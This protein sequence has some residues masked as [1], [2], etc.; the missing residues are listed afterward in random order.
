MHLIT[1]IVI[2]LPLTAID[3]FAMNK[4]LMKPAL[5][6]CT[7]TILIVVAITGS[8]LRLKMTT[9]LV[10]SIKLFLITHQPLVLIHLNG[11]GCLFRLL[12]LVF[13][14]HAGAGA[15]FCV[16]EIAWLTRPLQHTAVSGRGSL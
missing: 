15:K 1:G 4:V 5:D 11:F 12:F 2:F 13:H 3:A 16:F 6:A 7:L 10:K 8:Y 9:M 14:L